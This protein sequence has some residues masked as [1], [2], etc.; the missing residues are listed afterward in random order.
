ML[1]ILPI[2]ERVCRLRWMKA[3][4]QGISPA[5]IGTLAVSLLQMAPHA[6][7]D[8]FAALLFAL[9]LVVLLGWRVSALPVM[10]G[11]ALLG[12][13]RDRI[14]TLPGLRALF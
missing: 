9:A 14:V 1:S 11:G 12:W 4:L 6:V 13:L 8:R 5:V 2:Y 3:A 10:L 7:P